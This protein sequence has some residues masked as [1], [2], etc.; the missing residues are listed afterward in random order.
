MVF[1]ILASKW[2]V[3]VYSIFRFISVF[4]PFDSVLSDELSF[5]TKVFISFLILLG[6]WIIFILVISAWFGTRKFIEVFEVGNSK[7]VY[8]QYGDVFSKDE[9]K[10]EDTHRNIVIPVNRCFDTLV[11]DDLVSATTLHYVDINMRRLH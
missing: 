3:G 6:I 4:T 11:D 5:W 9:V 2:T 7:H 1:G 10:K 8:V